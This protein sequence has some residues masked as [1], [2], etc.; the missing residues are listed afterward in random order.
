MKYLKRGGPCGLARRPKAVPGSGPAPRFSAAKCA[1]AE[2]GEQR[3]DRHMHMRRAADRS[4]ADP[5]R[6]GAKGERSVEDFSLRGAPPGVY[7]LQ[8]GT[9]PRRAAPQ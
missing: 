4:A 7:K 1:A 6:P 3:S 8:T 9:Q 5:R 2:D